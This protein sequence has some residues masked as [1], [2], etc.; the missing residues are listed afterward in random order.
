VIHFTEGATDPLQGF[1]AQ[2]VRFVP[3]ADGGGDTH[4]SCLYLDAGA[5][6]RQPPS[7]HDCALLIVHGQVV[8]G[9]EGRAPRL[10][11]SP[12][13]GLV[14]KAGEHYM[15]ESSRGGIVL[16]FESDTPGGE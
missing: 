14:M 1:G 3:L 12:G 15:L 11:L 6:I 2:R 4:V 16:L 8:V 5:Q 9:G 10:D 7:T 13:V